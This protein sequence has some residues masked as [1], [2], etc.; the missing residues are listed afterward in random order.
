MSAHACRDD[1]EALCE[2]VRLLCGVDLLQYERG[3]MER[4]VRTW[5]QRRGAASLPGYG[6]LL[7]RDPDELD[8]FVDRVTIDVSHLWRHEEQWD[9][10]QQDVLHE[11]AA[12]SGRIRAWSAGSWNGAEAFTL[13]AVCREVV[14]EAP[15]TVVATDLDQRMVTRARTGEFSA[16]DARSTPAMVLHRHFQP[17]EGGAWRAS[18]A[19]RALVRFELGDPL[20]MPIPKARYDVIMGRN[21]GTGEVRDALH[22]RLVEALAPGGYLVVGASEGVADPRSLRLVRTHRFVYRK[23]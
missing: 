9:A 7:R 13:A 2:R 22:A 8:A 14:P 12:R 19:L 11:I 6:D 17:L 10:L 5:A 23:G 20:R 15:V 16:E 1:Y 3:Q 4:R 21:A 18:R